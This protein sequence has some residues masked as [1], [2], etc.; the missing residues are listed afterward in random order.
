M[1]NTHSYRLLQ[2]NVCSNCFC[3]STAFPKVDEKYLIWEYR[4][5]MF[6]QIFEE[7][8]PDLICLE[9]VDVLENFEAILSKK[10]YDYEYFR[11]KEGIQGIAFFY[12]KDKFN[13]LDREIV[14]LPKD[15][16]NLTPEN[17]SNQIFVYFV[18]QDISTLTTFIVIITHLKA[19][20]QFYEMRRV[21]TKFLQCY[22][23]NML[24]N[25]HNNKGIIICG[26]FN[27]EPD[28]KSI[29]QILINDNSDNKFLTE[30]NF[31]L[32]QSA[33]NFSNPN[34]EDY[35]ECTTFKIRE[36]EI[37][38]VIDYV[39]YDENFNNNFKIVEKNKLP[40]KTDDLIKEIIGKGLPCEKFPSDHFYLFIKFSNK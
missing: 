4:N 29:Q 26:D 14:T 10:N 16:I 19:K 9:E 39:F 37:Y 11:K 30:N 5:K 35:I 22:I 40:K 31:P 24:L 32:F 12:K 3:N 13:I 1:F 23:K 15:D 33:F 38:R 36:V 17:L 27:A 6:D 21:Q 8:N 28:E 7:L 2:W 34:K 20:K 25:I 18:V